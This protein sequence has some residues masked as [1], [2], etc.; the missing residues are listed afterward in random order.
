MPV[1]KVR[2]LILLFDVNDDTVVHGA[3][4]LMTS[5]ETL[6]ADPMS[7]KGRQ[8]LIDAC[9]EILQATTHLLDIYDDSEV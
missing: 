5:A 7:K 9:K 1:T 4:L 3:D 2:I 8:M 6:K